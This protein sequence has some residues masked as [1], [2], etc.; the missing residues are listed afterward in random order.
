[1]S[2]IR[3][4]NRL[5]HNLDSLTV[6]YIAGM[7]TKPTSAHIQLINNLVKSIRTIIT[8]KADVIYLGNINDSDDSYRNLVKN[9]HHGTREKQAGT[10]GLVWDS[11]WG[12]SNP[13]G[14]GWVDTHYN[15][16]TEGDK[17]TLNDA[18]IAVY[19]TTTFIEDGI[20][21]GSH[22]SS[23]YIRIRQYLLTQTFFSLNYSGGYGVILPFHQGLLL[24]IRTNLASDSTINQNITT[25]N[26]SNA[27]VTVPNINIFLFKENG[28]SPTGY[29]YKGGLNF[30]YIGASLTDAEY[31]T[32]NNAVN[33]YLKECLY[34]KYGA[35]N[36]GVQMAKSYFDTLHNFEPY[37]AFEIYE[38]IKR[39]Q[40]DYVDG[41]ATGYYYTTFQP[42]K[43]V[44]DF[45]M[46]F[47]AGGNLLANAWTKTGDTLRWNQDAAIASSNT[48]PAYTRGTNLG[49]VTVSSTDGW[50][51]VTTI[52]LIQSNSINCF[53][54]NFPRT[55]KIGIGLHYLLFTYN[56]MKIYLLNTDVKS[57]YTGLRDGGGTAYPGYCKLDLSSMVGGSYTENFFVTGYYQVFG[58]ITPFTDEF[59]KLVAS[60]S[61][62]YSPNVYGSLQNIIFSDTL[63]YFVISSI[64]ITEGSSSW[65]KYLATFSLLNCSLNTAALDAQLAVI[66]NYFASVIPIKNLTVNLSGATMGIPTG[67]ASNTDLLGIVAKHT[68]AGFTATI[69]VRTS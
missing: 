56:R 68:A 51:G 19:P 43:T 53:F 31:T 5:T 49:I 61:P 12:Y 64:G 37:E 29:P 57:Y 59:K 4:F 46:L 40:S 55:D 44:A 20:I 3:K 42:T 45:I 15:P 38:F 50:N 1:M 24:S 9:A 22:V 35:S 60:Y 36:W 8:T 6:A 25:V 65:N 66:N 18:G 17:Y 58:D 69:T 34:L 14:T 23:V 67:G 21:I 27:S 41:A 39:M 10:N 11:Y 47:K 28:G 48:M 7:A 32:L 54:N 52:N 2:G 26:K 30:T 16:S 62:S 63:T 13:D 33:L